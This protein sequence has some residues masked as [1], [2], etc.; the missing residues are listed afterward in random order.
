MANLTD[1]MIEIIRACVIIR[2]HDPRPRRV[3]PG[4][5]STPLNGEPPMSSSDLGSIFGNL[6]DIF[7]AFGDIATGSSGISSTVNGDGK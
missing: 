5:E 6:G 2:R 4:E 1:R 3:R 7:T